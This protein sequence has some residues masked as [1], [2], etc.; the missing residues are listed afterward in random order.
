[1]H[2]NDCIVGRLMTEDGSV[3]KSPFETIADV[4]NGVALLNKLLHR[5]EQLTAGEFSGYFEKLHS[6]A[7]FSGIDALASLAEKIW[8]QL[9][10]QDGANVLDAA[11]RQDIARNL[12]TYKFLLSRRVDEDARLAS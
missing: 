11:A 10:S 5:R 12:V 9:E 2:L 8:N 3:K 7:A 1:M 6:H 4:E